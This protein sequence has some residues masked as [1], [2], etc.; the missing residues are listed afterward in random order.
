MTLFARAW[1]AVNRLDYDAAE[2]GLREAIRLDPLYPNANWFHAG[3]GLIAMRRGNVSEALEHYRRAI[4]VYD[5][6]ARIYWEYAYALNCA[7]DPKNAID[8][9]K[10]VLELTTTGP[11]RLYAQNDLARAYLA[12]GERA[13]ANEVVDRALASTEPRS[14]LAVMLLVSV[15]RLDEARGLWDERNTGFF[16][17]FVHTAFGQYDQAIDSW[18]QAIDA[19]SVVLLSIRIDPAFAELRKDPRWPDVMRHLERVENEARESGRAAAP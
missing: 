7:G 11:F 13:I 14:D 9:A 16:A 18:D 1:V 15:G 5:A 12:L 8:A 2:S 10:K 3:L 4:R 19:R 17:P 6:D